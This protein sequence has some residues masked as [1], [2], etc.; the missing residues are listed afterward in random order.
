MDSPISTPPINLK[1]ARRQK[2]SLIDRLPPFSIEAE[3]GV[4]GCLILNAKDAHIPCVEK[5]PEGGDVF[6][7]IRHGAIYSAIIGL[8]DSGKP[9]DILTIQQAVKDSGQLEAVGGLAYLS[10]L[11][12]ATPSAANISY[13]ADIV[14]EKYMLRRMVSICTATVGRVYEYEG[15]AEDLVDSFEEEALSIRRT[16]TVVEVNVKES[17]RRGV[18]QMELAHQHPGMM[19]GVPSGFIDLDRMTRG[20]RPGNMFTIAARPSVGKTTLGMNI[21]EH[22]S[23][24][25]K[26]P[27]AIFSLEMGGDELIFRFTCS[28]ARVSSEKAMGGTM[29]QGDFK[30]IASSNAV[31]RTAP[32]HIIDRGGLSIAQIRAH[33]RRMVQKY[34][35][36][37]FVVDYLQLVS[38]LIGRNETRSTEVSKVSGGIKSMAMELGVPVIALSQ[39]N[40]DTERFKRE[41][42]LSDLRESGS[43]EQDS[44]GVLLLHRKSE[45]ADS[46]VWTIGA[47]LAKQRNGRTGKFELTLLRE[48]TRFESAS[49]VKAQAVAD[50]DSNW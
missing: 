1:T 30:K 26:L 35:V 38:A 6:Y 43:L 24:E 42:Q 25:L 15:K 7:D 19:W 11:P 40:R 9:A 18:D 41:P 45:D 13:Y 22:V 2:T 48:I 34:G 36:K 16:G 44:D 39:L 10:S 27:V 32:I 17:L 23:L 20:F 33:A 29:D 28:R 31:W 4:L 3:Q 5:F 14:A 8:I 12:E 46:P 37:L 49:R 47:N 50:S 21:A